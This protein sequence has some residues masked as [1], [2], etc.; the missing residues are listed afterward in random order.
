MV[1]C[2]E[3]EIPALS[4]VAG[5]WNRLLCATV[6]FVVSLNMTIQVSVTPHLGDVLFRYQND[7]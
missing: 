3:H 4:V 1:E 6:W 2:S 5:A 7:I